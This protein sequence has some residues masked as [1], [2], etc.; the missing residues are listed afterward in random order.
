MWTLTPRSLER[1]NLVAIILWVIGILYAC[2]TPNDEMPDVDFFVGFDK[3]MHF[4]FYLGLIFLLLVY[5][6]QRKDANWV[7]AIMIIAVAAFGIGIEYVQRAL[8]E[9]RSFSVADMLADCL[10]LLSGIII[11]L[12]IETSLEQ[13]LTKKFGLNN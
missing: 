10:G 6:L 2:L 1:L 9:G 5:R 12:F 7:A 3:L 13:Y 11:Y 4:L 8:N